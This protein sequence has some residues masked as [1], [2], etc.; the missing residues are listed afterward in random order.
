MR[1][2]PT[3][4]VDPQVQWIPAVADAAVRSNRS[5]TA[6]T[7]SIRRRSPSA[8]LRRLRFVAQNECSYP[9]SGSSASVEHRRPA[10][11]LDHRP[12]PGQARRRSRSRAAGRRT[13]RSPRRAVAANV[14]G[15][16]PELGRRPPRRRRASGSAASVELD[17]HAAAPREMAARRW[18]ARRTG[19]SSRWRRAPPA[20]GPLA[21]RGAGGRS[22]RAARRRGARRPA[23]ARPSSSASP[24]PAAPSVPVTATRSPG[25]APSRPDQLG[26]DRRAQPTTVNDTVSAGA[27]VTSPP[28]IVTPSSSAS[29]RAPPTSASGILQ[30]EPGGQR[31]APGRPRP[32][33]R[34]SPPGPRRPR[35]SARWP[36]SAGRRADRS[37]SG[38]RRPSRRPRSRRSA[39]PAPPRRRRRSSGPRAASRARR[40]TCQALDQL[41][42]AH[43]S[44]APEAT[45]QRCR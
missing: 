28:A 16:T 25:R 34:P 33:G 13:A 44:G 37:G 15:S 3:G 17:P 30:L 27:R 42:L 2:V 19:R 40:S 18:P 23:Q 31:R 4:A 43:R 7:A 10:V 12:D 11:P 14:A 24:A 5:R 26:R 41:E 22:A 32:A 39:R 36:I 1:L 29:S 6:S 38:R 20:R 21:R 9:A 8:M 35:A 45:A